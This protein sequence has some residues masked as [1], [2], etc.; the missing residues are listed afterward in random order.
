MIMFRV[1]MDASFSLI[2]IFI[3]VS[4]SQGLVTI[5]FLAAS[6]IGIKLGGQSLLSAMRFSM[7]VIFPR[8]LLL[9]FLT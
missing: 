8:L 1:S 7:V 5:K 6:C 3:C 2:R 9:L 4:F